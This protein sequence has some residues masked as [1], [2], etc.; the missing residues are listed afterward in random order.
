MSPEVHAGRTFLRKGSY[1]FTI[2]T[3]VI[4]GL[5]YSY[6]FGIDLISKIIPSIPKPHPLS[7]GSGYLFFFDITTSV[8]CLAGSICF[9]YLSLRDVI[10]DKHHY[11]IRS[12]FVL[13]AN[14]L[15]IIG[16]NVQYLADNIQPAGNLN[17]T[18]YSMSLLVILLIAA[19]LIVAIIDKYTREKK[20]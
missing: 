20:G 18:L 14:C 19:V 3:L 17:K 2:L 15:V 6:V 11:N 10:A 12:E 8:F 5:I 1:Y 13:I 9:I 4:L 7:S 16:L